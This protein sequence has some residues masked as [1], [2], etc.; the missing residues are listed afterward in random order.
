LGKVI[1]Y[2][3]NRTSNLKD[4]RVLKSR[5]HIR[6][7]PPMYERVKSIRCDACSKPPRRDNYSKSSYTMT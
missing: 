6:P 4:T 3:G 2:E 5:G 1:K 7:P